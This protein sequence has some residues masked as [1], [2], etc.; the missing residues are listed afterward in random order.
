MTDVMVQEGQGFSPPPSL[1]H[2]RAFIACIFRCTVHGVIV[3]IISC[4]GLQLTRLNPT[5]DP[6]LCCVSAGPRE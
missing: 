5:L 4:V 3:K 2:F 6:L 1:L